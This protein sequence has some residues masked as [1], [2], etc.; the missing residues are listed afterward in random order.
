[1]S[2][3]SG[4]S[5]DLNSSV[6]CDGA[7]SSGLRFRCSTSIRRRT[8]EF[9][10]PVSEDGVGKRCGVASGSDADNIYL[11]ASYSEDR[12]QLSWSP[13]GG[14]ALVGDLRKRQEENEQWEREQSSPATRT[15]EPA[16]ATETAEPEPASDTEA[17]D[18][19]T[20]AVSEETCA[21][22]FIDN[23]KKEARKAYARLGGRI[24]AAIGV[25][26]GYCFV[27][28]V[29]PSGDGYAW[30]EYENGW[31]PEGRSRYTQKRIDHVGAIEVPA[32][33]DG[34]IGIP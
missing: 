14:S 20:R 3:L 30:T 18:F 32:S 13:G 21:Y 16:N 33:S 7:D 19:S 29:T 31:T 11:V 17:P 22:G 9:G 23:V 34:S 10:T 24:S 27:A 1:V 15:P 4:S 8:N 12:G 5:F 25:E 28:L 6:N 26:D 2:A